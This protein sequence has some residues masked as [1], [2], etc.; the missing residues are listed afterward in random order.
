MKEAKGEF[1]QG[2]KSFMGFFYFIENDK[3]FQN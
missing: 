1:A 2:A 3:I